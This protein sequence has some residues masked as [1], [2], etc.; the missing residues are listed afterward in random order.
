MDATQKQETQSAFRLTKGT[1]T[2]E[3]VSYETAFA[4]LG[5]DSSEKQIEKMF[6][7]EIKLPSNEFV[8]ANNMETLTAI[9]EKEGW[10]NEPQDVESNARELG[11]SSELEYI[12]DG[13]VTDESEQLNVPISAEQQAIIDALD[14]DIF[15]E[16]LNDKEVNLIVALGGMQKFV[17]GFNKGETK[18][19]ASIK[20]KFAKFETLDENGQEK[21]SEFQKTDALAIKDADVI[22][23]VPELPLSEE[24]IALKLS[25]EH[26]IDLSIGEVEVATKQIEKSGLGMMKA[27]AEIKD[28]RLF[29][30]EGEFAEYAI[31]R[32][33]SITTKGYAHN[34]AQYGKFLGVFNEVSNIDETALNT[35]AVRALTEGSNK[36][37][38]EIGL[39]KSEF[40]AL[41]PII[42]SSAQLI[43]ELCTDADGNVKYNPLVIAQA[44]KTIAEVART[45]TVTINGKSMTVEKA[46]EKGL[47]SEAVQAEILENVVEQIKTRK[48]YI[49][50]EMDKARERRFAPQEPIAPKASKRPQFVGAVPIYSVGC[51]NPNHKEAN[52][53]NG[54]RIVAVISAGFELACSCK[55][56]KLTVSGDN[57]VCVESDGLEIQH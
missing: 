51:D 29:R 39:G 41:R 26:T 45:S 12:P 22:E 20:K 35:R 37:A 56:Q 11:E 42:E 38:D 54:N 48:A 21:V 40:A 9:A 15:R 10:T 32:F 23:A 43:T 52:K 25:L 5:E 34:L 53:K 18:L 2:I 1:A 3:A 8:Y 19:Y 7:G 36:I 6:A 16:M 14:N 31:K 50:D 17:A 24:E 30:E 49:T 33:P 27:F 13:E 55:F 47:L 44:Q 46:K 4:D 28:K 57:F